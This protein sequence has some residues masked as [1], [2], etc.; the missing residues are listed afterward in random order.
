MQ[1]FNEGRKHHALIVFALTRKGLHMPSTA[2]QASALVFK[3]SFSIYIIVRETRRRNQEILFL[4]RQ[5]ATY[6]GEEAA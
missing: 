2:L 5:A 4:T 6:K 3:L 1:C